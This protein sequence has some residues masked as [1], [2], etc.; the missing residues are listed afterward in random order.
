MPLEMKNSASTDLLS[1]LPAVFKS[2]KERS[3]AVSRAVKAGKARALGN[4]LYTTDLES[5]PAQLIQTR[6]WQ[7]V[8]MLCPDCTIGYR[9]AIEGRPAQAG[10]RRFVVVVGSYPRRIDLPGLT[11]FQLA[12]LSPHGDDTPF[13][14]EGL[15]IASE[16]RALLENMLPSKGQHRRTLGREAVEARL[17]AILKSDRGHERLN[18]IRD[19]ARKAAPALQLEPQF[20]ELDGMIGA[21]LETRPSE[22]L[23]SARP[24]AFVQG[25]GYDQ[26]RLDLLAMLKLRLD[27]LLAVDRPEQQSEAAFRHAAFFDAYFSN[28]IEGTEF[29]V[30]E[31]KGIVLRGQIPKT[32][33]A[34]AHDILGTFDIVGSPAAMRNP[35]RDPVA[36]IDALKAHHATIMKGRTDR[37]PG[38]FKETGNRA[39]GYEFVHPH[40]VLGTLRRGFEMMNGIDDP[41]SRAAFIMFLIAEVHPFDDGNGRTARAFMNAELISRGQSRIIVPS[42]YRYEYLAGLGR[43][44]RERDPDTLIRVLD[45]AHAFTDAIDFTDLERATATLDRCNAFKRPEDGIRL[46]WPPGAAV[47][48]GGARFAESAAKPAADS[49][50]QRERAG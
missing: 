11:I 9:T 15:R 33:P 37:R 2:T 39:G 22:L 30:E 20:A 14:N 31:A 25:D 5:D 34:D 10:D 24:K 45:H 27:S 48:D 23:K 28:F 42:V 40:E 50:Q 17:L 49:G 47:Y 8:A 19:R 21:L 35:P 38:E 29:E 4:T 43:M 32:R 16:H 18:Q 46:L 12:G 1:S 26:V 13:L 41:F 44:S 36:L 3:Q 7:V 6:I